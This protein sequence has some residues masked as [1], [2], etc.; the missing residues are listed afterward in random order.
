MQELQNGI[1]MFSGH[2]HCTLCHKHIYK[3]GVRRL[4]AGLEADRGIKDLRCDMLSQRGGP[5]EDFA[6]TYITFAFYDY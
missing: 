6:S 2:Q 4:P 5:N 3:H 1:K